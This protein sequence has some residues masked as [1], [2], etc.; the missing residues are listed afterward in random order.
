MIPHPEPPPT[1]F[2]ADFLE[3]GERGEC[4][5][6]IARATDASMELS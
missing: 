1:N 2:Q 4:T 6:L 3:H 5:Q